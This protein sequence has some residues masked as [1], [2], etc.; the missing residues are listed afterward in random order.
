[1]GLNRFSHGMRSRRKL[2][3]KIE[4]GGLGLVV[5]DEEKIGL[6]KNIDEVL[7]EAASGGLKWR[8][9]ACGC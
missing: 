7:K 1:V 9:R 6:M 3:V 4:S 5:A 8:F 2:Q